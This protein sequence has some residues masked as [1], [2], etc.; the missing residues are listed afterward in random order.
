MTSGRALVNLDNI[1]LEYEDIIKRISKLILRFW[2]R[3]LWV[4][5]IPYMIYGISLRLNRLWLSQLASELIG[6]RISRVVMWEIWQKIVL[7]KSNY[8]FKELVNNPSSPNQSASV[9]WFQWVSSVSICN[10]L[11]VYYC[12]TRSFSWFLSF[13]QD[14]N[15][16]L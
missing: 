12:W 1:G 15:K 9:I 5:D 10:S 8:I 4:Y 7:A 13:K 3:S 2:N 16:K 11:V 6:L 14:N